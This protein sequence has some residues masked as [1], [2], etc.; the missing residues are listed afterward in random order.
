[1][2]DAELRQK[3]EGATPLGDEA[4]PIWGPL[5]F[6][7]CYCGLLEVPPAFASTPA[8]L[9]GA[10]QAAALSSRWRRQLQ[11]LIEKHA[12]DPVAALDALMPL[13]GEK[14]RRDFC[15]VLTGRC[16]YSPAEL[17]VLWVERDR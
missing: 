3:L 14:H 11:A 15:A 2:G 10:R 9:I 17:S 7:A 6:W 13:A 16:R 12:L 8:P 1:M 4:S 5:E